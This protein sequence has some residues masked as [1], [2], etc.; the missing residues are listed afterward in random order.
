MQMITNVNHVNGDKDDVQSLVHAL[1]YQDKIDIVGIASSTSRHQPGAND[2]KFIHHVID[3]YA[4]DQRKL[5]LHGQP[6]D[7]KVESQLHAI[8]YQGTTELS[9]LIGYPGAATDASNA[10]IEEAREAKAAGEPLYVATWGGMGDVARA[11]H[12]APDIASSIRLIS[13][14]GPAQDPQ[15]YDYVV[16]NFVGKD[17]FWWID[18]QTTQRGIYAGESDRFPPYVTLAEVK[19]FA[20]AHGN[21]GTFF[22]ENSNDLRGTGGGYH[23]LKMSDS[24]TVLYLIDNANNDDPTA[25]SWGGEYKQVGPGYWK[26]KTDASETLEWS[27]SNGARTT[28][29]DRAV[30]LSDFRARFDW[31][32]DDSAPPPQPG[33]EL[34]ST[35]APSNPTLDT[36]TVRISGS[37]YKGYPNFSLL[38][39]DEIVDATSLVTADY[40]KGVWETFTFTGDFGAD[41]SQSVRIGIKFTNDRYGGATGDR[42]LY[43]DEV[44]FN[45]QVDGLDRK[46]TS[47]STSYWDFML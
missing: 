41:G 24:H 8:T 4:V 21:L 39:D 22:Y 36:V 11:L 31:L 44:M 38:I 45:G 12:D 47:N 5:A 23:G 1:M 37:E 35:E 43:V 9:N 28:Y 14:S 40:N 6:G 42:N 26:D 25:E 30:W 27:G 15:A 19:E 29:E 13:A 33:E 32:I 2:A 16:D 10:I 20:D 46:L 18:A 3:E 34:P 17:G 7:F